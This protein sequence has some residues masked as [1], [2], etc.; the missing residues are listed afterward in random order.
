[1]IK[2][3]WSLRCKNGSTETPI[4]AVYQ[5]NRTKDTKLMIVPMNV[6][7]AFDKIKDPFFIKTLNKFGIERNYLDIIKATYDKP[8]ANLMLSN[9]KLKRLQDQNKTKMPALTT[10]IWRSPGNPGWS[11]W[12]R[13]WDQSIPIGK[14]EVNHLCLILYVE[15]TPKTPQDKPIRIKK[16]IRQSFRIKKNQ[17]TEISWDHL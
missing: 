12:V 11:H 7:K 1:M 14:E 2:W 3:E 4:N 15:K 6:E 17:H 8:T 16:E 9:E 13:K 5:M 10:S